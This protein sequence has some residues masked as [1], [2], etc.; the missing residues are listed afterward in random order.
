MEKLMASV[1]EFMVEYNIK[2]KEEDMILVLQDFG[3]VPKFTITEISRIFTRI[4]NELEIFD[5][6]EILKKNDIYV[7]HYNGV[8]YPLFKEPK[9]GGM[10]SLKAILF[11]Y[12]KMRLLTDKS[13][14]GMLPAKFTK[15]VYYKVLLS[16]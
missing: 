5:S 10:V 16:R 2:G 3:T 15:L 1:K 4:K 11:I 8:E 13:F 6:M 14:S 7:I 12:K 9:E